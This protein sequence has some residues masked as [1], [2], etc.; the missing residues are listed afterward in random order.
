MGEFSDYFSDFSSGDSWL[1]I[2]AVVSAAVAMVACA[3]YRLTHSKHIDSNGKVSIVRK[4]QLSFKRPIQNPTKQKHTQAKKLKPFTR[5]QKR[6]LRL[7]YVLHEA[8]FGLI[9]FFFGL[10][11]LTK[12]FFDIV[13]NPQGSIDAKMFSYL[14]L[15][16]AALPV[17]V[18]FVY[19]RDAGNPFGKK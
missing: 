8:V 16:T 10:G 5:K 1:G 11:L 19:F 18:L 2:A 12:V 4:H 3:A 9:V 15:G 13:G 14:L 6:I 17:G 7:V